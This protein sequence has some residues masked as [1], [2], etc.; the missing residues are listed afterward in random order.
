MGA[1]YL[2]DY[3]FKR[4]SGRAISP[5]GDESIAVLVVD[6][7]QALLIRFRYRE[8]VDG[9]SREESKLALIDRFG[10]CIQGLLAF[11]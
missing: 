1:D 9:V 11:E 3:D 6:R 2:F 4:L 10:K 8:S 7:P 5:G